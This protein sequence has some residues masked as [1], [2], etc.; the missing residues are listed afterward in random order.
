MEAVVF[1]DPKSPLLGANVF[2]ASRIPQQL[3]TLSWI[4]LLIVPLAYRNAAEKTAS[5]SLPANKSIPNP[6]VN[7]NLLISWFVAFDTTKIM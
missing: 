2:F 1:Y 5:R 3:I 7:E 4:G 6:I